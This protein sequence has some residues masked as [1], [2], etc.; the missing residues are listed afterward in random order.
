MFF[1][2]L[3]D[4]GLRPA[5]SEKMFKKHYNCVFYELSKNSINR[6]SNHC[7]FSQGNRAINKYVLILAMST[8]SVMKKIELKHGTANSS[9]TVIPFGATITSW[10]I[11]GQEHI[12]VSKN[13]IMDGS[14]A[15]RGGK[16]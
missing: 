14:K 9:V 13:A 3:H 10:K 1:R 2:N 15:I 5:E 8:D 11:D 12:F 16:C 7:N 4:K 6:L